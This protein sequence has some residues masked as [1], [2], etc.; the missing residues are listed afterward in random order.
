M[1]IRITF[2]SNFI[3]HHQIPFCEEM[4]SRLHEDFSFVQVMPMDQQRV[5]MGWGEESSRIPYLHKLYEE[6]EFC[7][8]LILD[9]D[10]LILGWTGDDKGEKKDVLIKERLS[11]GKPVI[12]ISERIYREGR[13]KAVSPRGLIA[14]Y[15]EHIK[16]KAKPVYML[17]AGAYVSG[18][19]KLLGAYP[20]KMFKWGY[21][22]P[23]KRFEEDQLQEM[24][25]KEKEKL[26]LCFVARLIKLKHPEFALYVAEHLR[27]RGIDFHMDIV[28]DGPLRSE[29]EATVKE[30]GL[31]DKITFHGSME[32]D[33][34]RRVM[35]NSHVF[36]FASNYLEGW[37]AVV[38]EAMN[39]ACAVVAS[40]E[41]GAVPFLIKDKENGLSFDKCSKDELLSKIDY[42]IDEPGRISK[43]QKAAYETIISE[44]NAEVA[45]E[46]FLHFCKNITAD[47]SELKDIPTSGPMSR[48]EV[49]KAPGFI[50]T[51]QE[52][53]HLE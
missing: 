1:G 48:A 13:Y 21:F 10:V 45:G 17:C 50:R 22:P 2:V 49:L 29:L 7:T 9:C 16:Y 6:E 26:R 5:E 40:K 42:L 15:H 30:K 12:R 34:V 46:R 37:G 20:G 47:N 43:F 33:K 51:L 44:W 39:S 36:I 53:N 14:K 27:N 28:G 38:N 4:Y 3:N 35:E 24:L 18:D 19:F 31:A 25:Y 32:P 8:R 23:L 41:A 11:S 52:D